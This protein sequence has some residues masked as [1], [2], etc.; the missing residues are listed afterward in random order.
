M[1]IAGIF[2]LIIFPYSISHVFFGDRG[3]G[4]LGNI[5]NMYGS[6]SNIIIYLLIIYDTLNGCNNK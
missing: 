2:S 3:Q 6:L 5:T 4:V 1:L